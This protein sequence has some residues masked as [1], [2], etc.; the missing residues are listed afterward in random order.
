MGRLNN[1]T[2]YSDPLSSSRAPLT[3]GPR[4]GRADHMQ[5]IGYPSERMP[6]NVK[7]Y[8]EAKFLDKSPVPINK[9]NNK[10]SSSLTGGA[11]RNSSSGSSGTGPVPAAA[12]NPRSAHRSQARQLMP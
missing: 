4:G 2:K 7:N 9:H 3:G 10:G 11:Q 6:R 8:G 5:T 1:N 12:F